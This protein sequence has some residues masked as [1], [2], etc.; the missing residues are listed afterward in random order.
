MEKNPL[1]R[2]NKKR[3][4]AFKSRIIGQQMIYFQFCTLVNFI[5]FY[6]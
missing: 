6:K 5:C 2:I 4:K 3:L 1:I